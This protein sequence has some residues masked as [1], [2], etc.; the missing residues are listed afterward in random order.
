MAREWL[1]PFFE[2]LPVYGLFFL[3]V[4][5][6]WALILLPRDEWRNRPT[7]LALGLAL[8]PLFGTTWLFILGTWGEFFVERALAGIVL[9]S[10]IGVTGA[11]LRRNTGYLKTNTRP[12]PWT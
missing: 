7:V 8:G 12:E 6:P 1:W 4:G 11:W 10:I 2:Y 5:I 9:L 3:G